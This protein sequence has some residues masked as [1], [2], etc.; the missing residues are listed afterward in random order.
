MR[1][2]FFILSLFALSGCAYKFNAASIPVEMK[3][4][5]VLYFEN[6]AQLVVP[7]LSQRLTEDLKTLIRD[8]SR[9]SLTQ[10]EADAVFT[11]KITDYNIKPVAIVDNA[12][13]IAGANRLTITVSVKYTVNLEK[14]KK[15]SYEQSFSAFT[16]FTLAGNSLQSQE[17]ELIKK[18]NKQLV[19]NIFNRAFA[20][21]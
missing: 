16:D 9:L 8:Q 13:P 6:N 12:R 20:Q 5:S 7:N 11:G 15:Q 17:Q 21:W 18:V 1:K 3:T 2:L 19:E 10:G 14:E 4:V